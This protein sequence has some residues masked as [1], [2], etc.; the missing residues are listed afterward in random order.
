MNGT[1]T[2]PL[3]ILLVTLMSPSKEFHNY[4]LMSSEHGDFK[5][6][7]QTY[8]GQGPKGTIKPIHGVADHYNGVPPNAS[9]QPKQKNSH[10][11]LRDLF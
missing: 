9:E 8:T 6:V 5:P 4:V 1:R 10:S 7:L 2:W 11:A 3:H